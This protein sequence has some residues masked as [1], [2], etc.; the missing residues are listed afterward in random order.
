MLKGFVCLVLSISESP[1][2]HR[3]KQPV[4]SHGLFTCLS[5]SWLEAST[6]VR[7]QDEMYLPPTRKI[8]NNK[9]AVKTRL[10]LTETLIIVMMER[11]CGRQGCCCLMASLTRQDDFPEELYD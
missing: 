6:T 4:H 1:L 8:K 3:L 7:A 9:K 2:K 5:V 10:I 11:P